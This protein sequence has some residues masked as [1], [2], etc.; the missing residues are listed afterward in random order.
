MA[1]AD[2]FPPPASNLTANLQE[3]L[4]LV[5]IH[6]QVSGTRRG[7]RRNVEVLNKSGIVLLVACWEAFIED[8]ADAA[9]SFLL[10]KATNPSVFPGP[11]LVQSTKG[12]RADKDESKIWALAGNGWRQVLETHRRSV[13][14]QYIGKLNTPKPKQI[15]ELFDKLLGIRSLSATWRWKGVSARNAATRLEDLIVLRG[16]IAHRVTAGR[17]VLKRDVRAG[18]DLIEHLAVCSSNAVRKW[19]IQRTSKVPWDQIEFE[20]TTVSA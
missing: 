20:P 16:E 10:E 13:T 3:V 1:N 7:R 9:F 15:D 17:A 4:R 8:L 11:V 5:G 19:L 18:V 2:E 14:E 6:E 12:L